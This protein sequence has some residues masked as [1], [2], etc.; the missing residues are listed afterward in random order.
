MKGIAHTYNRIFWFVKKYVKPLGLKRFGFARWL[1]AFIAIPVS[2]SDVKRSAGLIRALLKP[3]DTFVDVGANKGILCRAALQRR[4]NVVAI[5]ANPT[6]CRKLRK[7]PIQVEECAAFSSPGRT[8][9]HLSDFGS[10]F[11]SLSLSAVQAVSKGEPG[12]GTRPV[13]V[14]QETLDNLVREVHL[15]KID[16]QGAE[17]H[18]LRGAERTLRE[19][20]PVILVECWPSGLNF[21]GDSEED[22][23]SFLHGRHYATLKLEGGPNWYDILAIPQHEANRH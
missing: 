1:N 19:H 2:D 11:S 21:F 6:L 17:L 8:T 5:E 18:V 3:G 23:L 14:R 20:R 7:L 9:F 13:E 10:V 22:L 12:A 15:L 16:T 4:A